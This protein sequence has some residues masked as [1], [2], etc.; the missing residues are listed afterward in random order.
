MSRDKP[1]FRWQARLGCEIVTHSWKQLNL[2]VSVQNAVWHQGHTFTC[3]AYPTY[4]EEDC[5]QI[6]K[7]LRKVIQACT[8]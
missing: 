8:K 5:R 6:G 1:L 7:A 4:T 2:S 3:F